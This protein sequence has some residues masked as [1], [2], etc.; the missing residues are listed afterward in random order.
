MTYVVTTLA[1]HL[2]FAYLELIPVTAKG[3]FLMRVLIFKI[4]LK[5]YY[6]TCKLKAVMTD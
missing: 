5:L 2:I 4:P 3:Q 1:Q 6:Y